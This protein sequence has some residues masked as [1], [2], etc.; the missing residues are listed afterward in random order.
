[1][2]IKVVSVVSEAVAA[3]CRNVTVSLEDSFKPIFSHT[4]FGADI[5]E[6]T[7]A[8]VAVDEDS[9]TN[10]RFCEPHNKAGR[11]KHWLTQE[12]VKFISFAL[13]FNPNDIEG[14]AES[15]VIRIFFEAALSRLDN[16]G[17]K[18]PRGF[19]YAG[20]AAK[21]KDAAGVILKA[22]A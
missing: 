9:A 16:P 21:F 8:I 6:F 20:F 4:D 12:A 13:P 1:M 14:R 22:A 17:V 19:D 7:F 15:E 18:M 10:G 2:E 3:V 5:K 11:Y